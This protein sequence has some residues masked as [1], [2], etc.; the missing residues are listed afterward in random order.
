MRA[1]A[2]SHSGGIDVVAHD[3]E[4]LCKQRFSSFLERTAVTRLLTIW[5]A[6]QAI[7]VYHMAD[8]AAVF[9]MPLHAPPR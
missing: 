2:M 6:K 8:F 1:A 7:G 3:D 4:I 5:H 9:E